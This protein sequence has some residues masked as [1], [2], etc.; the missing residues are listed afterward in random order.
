MVKCDERAAVMVTCKSLI[1]VPA[2]PSTQLYEYASG[3]FAVGL[4][5][6]LLTADGV[7][8]SLKLLRTR[9]LCGSSLKAKPVEPASLQSA[10]LKVRLGPASCGG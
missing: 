6:T 10:Q 2:S 8:E 7:T 3:E 4:R 1:A 9:K 5:L